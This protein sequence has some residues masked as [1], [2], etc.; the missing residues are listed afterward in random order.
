MKISPATAGFVKGL[1]IA[2]VLAVVTFVG[3]T[4]NLEGLVT[5]AIATVIAAMASAIESSLKAKSGG[6]T[7]LF[8]AVKVR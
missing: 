1:L 2:V 3:N 6:S 8:G 7:A 4:A 5:P